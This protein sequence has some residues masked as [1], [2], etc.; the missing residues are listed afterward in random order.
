MSKFYRHDFRKVSTFDICILGYINVIQR[1]ERFSKVWFITPGTFIV[2]VI[3]FRVKCTLN[4]KMFQ[5]SFVHSFIHSFTNSFLH[6][7]ILPYDRSIAFSKASSRHSAIQGFL[8]ESPESCLVLKVIL[9]LLTS[10]SS[11]RHL[12]PSFYLSFS[13]MFQTAVLKQGVTNPLSL[14]S[15]ILCGMLLPSFLPPLTP[16]NT[17]LFLTQSVQPIFFIFSRIIFQN[18]PAISV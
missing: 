17:S 16:R 5:T 7:V 9:Y 6:F 1:N 10:F 14:S 2:C 13:S 4:Y 15:F 3:K 18:F 12:Y 11:S 8:F